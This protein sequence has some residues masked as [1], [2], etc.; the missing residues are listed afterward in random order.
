MSDL[1]A[2]CKMKC[3]GDYCGGD[4]ANDVYYSPGLYYMELYFVAL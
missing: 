3:G 4:L 2:D 1:C